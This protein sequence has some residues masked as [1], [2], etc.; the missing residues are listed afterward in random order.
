[1]VASGS[2]QA[3]LSTIADGMAQW[4][5][6]A[7]SDEKPSAPI[8]SSWYS[9]PSGARNWVCRFGGIRPAVR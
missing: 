3:R 4:Y 8:N 9:P 6:K 2:S 1:M 5:S 7:E